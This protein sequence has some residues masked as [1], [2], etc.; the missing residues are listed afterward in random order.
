MGLAGC[1]AN[2][3]PTVLTTSV[4]PTSCFCIRLWNGTDRASAE[5]EPKRIEELDLTFKPAHTLGAGHWK[6]STRFPDLVF[7]QNLS[8]GEARKRITKRIT[9]KEPED[10]WDR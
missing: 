3:L 9:G 7:L 2:A 4:F 1:R 6:M 10:F 8:K 5:F